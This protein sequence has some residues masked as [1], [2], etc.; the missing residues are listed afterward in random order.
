MKKTEEATC[1]RI[2]GE[3]YC[4]VCRRTRTACRAV[5]IEDGKILL[6]Y[7]KASD[8]WMLPGGGLE[9]GE[10]E[11]ECAVRE[12]AEETGYAV[13]VS[14]C[15]LA[16]EEYYDDCRYL[17]KYFPAQTI[18]PG[19]PSLTEEERRIG[20]EARWLPIGDAVAIF[21]KHA[22]YAENDECKRGLYLREYTALKNL[23]GR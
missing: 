5:V 15:L 13:A 16:I 2:V 12:V 4:G 1:V 6:S 11:E 17:T 9:A 14:P 10:S 7:A 18:G 3:N 8:V 22:E 20:L 23:K 19:E 21:A